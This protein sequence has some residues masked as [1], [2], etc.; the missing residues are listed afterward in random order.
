MFDIYLRDEPYSGIAV[1]C[2]EICGRIL[3]MRDNEYFD[4][5]RDELIDKLG[6]ENLCLIN[7]IVCF[8]S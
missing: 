2:R 1:A 7:I 6:S 8:L 4:R 3:L 5:I